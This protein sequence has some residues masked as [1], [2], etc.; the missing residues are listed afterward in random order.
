MWLKCASYFYLLYLLWPIFRL[1][2]HLVGGFN[3]DSKTSHELSFNILGKGCLNCLI[4][5]NIFLYSGLIT[6][7]KDYFSIAAAFHRQKDDIHLETCCITGNLDMSF[8]SIVKMSS[9]L[10]LSDFLLWI[11]R[12]K[13]HGSWWDSQAC[14]IWNRWMMNMF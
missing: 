13:W 14:S 3:D 9:A 7:N 8:A 5:C 11:C 1:E 6:L 12:N 4:N 2:L 10:I